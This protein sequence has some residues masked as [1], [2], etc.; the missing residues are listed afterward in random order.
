MAAPRSE[1]YKLPPSSRIKHGRDFARIKA[2]GARMA[3]GC[4]A[5]NWLLL[6]AGAGSRLA[7][8]TSKRLGNAVKRN[9]ARRLL[10]EAFRLHQHDLNQPLDIVLIARQSIA[11]KKLAQVEEDF[12]TV[13]RRGG[14]IK[15]TS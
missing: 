3:K 5:A 15:G 12:L 10:R 13:L 8:I 9:R 14:L 11:D 4:L 6:P 7:V 1:S 2:E